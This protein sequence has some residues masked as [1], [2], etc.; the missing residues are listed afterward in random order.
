MMANNQKRFGTPTLVKMLPADTATI[1]WV[2]MAGKG[3]SPFLLKSVQIGN[4]KPHV[5]PH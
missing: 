1:E 4:F 3:F 5:A 2:M